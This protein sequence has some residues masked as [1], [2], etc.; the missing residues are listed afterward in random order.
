MKKILF[1]GKRLDNGE[2]VHGNLAQYVEGVKAT[3]NTEDFCPCEE[4][5]FI[6]VDPE[7]VDFYTGKEKEC[8]A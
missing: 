6:C 1:R 2:W 4:S 7:T 8:D 3:I 5:R